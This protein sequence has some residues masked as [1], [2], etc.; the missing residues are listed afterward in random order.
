MTINATSKFRRDTFT[1]LSYISVAYFAYVEA[2][3]IPLTRHLRRYR[4]QLRPAKITA[5]LL[6]VLAGFVFWCCR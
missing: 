5:T 4:T 1:W 3:L 6:D 2:V